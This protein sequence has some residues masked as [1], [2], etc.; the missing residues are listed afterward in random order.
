MIHVHCIRRHDQ[1][2]VCADTCVYVFTDRHVCRQSIIQILYNEPNGISPSYF[3]QKENSKFKRCSTLEIHR[4]L[5]AL[6]HII[7]RYS[8]RISGL[9]MGCS[10]YGI[11]VFLRELTSHMLYIPITFCTK[12]IQESC[13]EIRFQVFNFYLTGVTLCN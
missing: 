9:C 3:N 10:F 1:L 11:F 5:V 7:L 8:V 2:C 4:L 12:H 6:R 13:Y